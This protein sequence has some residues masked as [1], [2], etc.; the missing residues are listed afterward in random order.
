[1]Y[2]V[3]TCVVSE[4]RRRTP[5]AVAWLSSARSE[6]LY[7]SAIT[8][9]EIMKGSRPVADALIAATAQ[10][11]NK[12]LVTRNVTAFADTGVTVLDPWAIMR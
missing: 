12:V 10:V 6:T 8:I 2:L 1:M 11:N 5:E 9:G 3:D 4:A 7:L